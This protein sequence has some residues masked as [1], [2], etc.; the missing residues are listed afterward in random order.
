MGAQ[1]SG[2]RKKRRAVQ[3]G[4]PPAG[5]PLCEP[6]YRK[7]V[8]GEAF[9]KKASEER[10]LFGKSRYPKTFMIFINVL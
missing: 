4:S 3:R 9:S 2:C 7:E 6:G 1:N 5:Q 8:F 10:R